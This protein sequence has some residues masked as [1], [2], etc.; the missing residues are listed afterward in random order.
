MSSKNGESVILNVGT[1]FA[2]FI[3]WIMS[4]TT[5]PMKGW[6]QHRANNLRPEPC[7]CGK[8]KYMH[9]LVHKDISFLL[10][11]FLHGVENSRS[12]SIIVSQLCPVWKLLLGSVSWARGPISSFSGK[13]LPNTSMQV[14]TKTCE[15]TSMWYFI[16]LGQRCEDIK[17]PTR[18]VVISSIGT[19]RELWCM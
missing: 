6:R 13:L 16:G 2:T 17:F 8:R 19:L 18:I 12:S 3:R 11:S 5:S 7:G 14:H 9:Q 4:G 15:A 10:W 1:K